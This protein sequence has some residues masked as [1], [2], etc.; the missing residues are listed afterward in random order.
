MDT[1]CLYYLR[2]SEQETAGHSF[3]GLF[4]LVHLRTGPVLRSEWQDDLEGSF[5]M[6]TALGDHRWNT[7]R[8]W[9]CNDGSLVHEGKDH[10]E[11]CRP[12]QQAGQC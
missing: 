11:T 8:A 5:E 10:G 1:Y 9:L 2:L 3:I 4:C 7:V 12:L 6:S